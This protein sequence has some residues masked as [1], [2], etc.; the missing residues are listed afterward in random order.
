[1]PDEFD[2]LPTPS[3]IEESDQELGYAM[4]HNPLSRT[5]YSYVKTGEIIIGLGRGGSGSLTIF[6][7]K[8]GDERIT[9]RKILSEAMMTAKWTRQ[10]EGPMLPPFVKAR[11]Q[12]EY[13][14]ALPRS[15]R[16]YFPTASDVIEREIPIPVDLR[17]DG[18][19]THREVIYEMEYVPGEDVS[20]FIEKHSPPTAVVARLYA[21]ILSV[22][23]RVVHTFDRVPAPG[24]TLD[25]SYFKKIEDRLAVCRRTAPSTFNEHLLGT[26]RILINGVPYLNWSTLLARFRK[27]PE[28]L[29]I[30]E[31]PFHSLVMGD[32]NTENIK[33]TNVAPLI[34]AQRLIDSHASAEDVDRAL[35]S[36]TSESLGIRFL[37][38]R[39]VG[40]RSVGREARDDPMYDNKPWHNS[41]GHYD[42]IHHE[43]FTLRIRFDVRHTPCV[44]IE[45]IDGNP[46]QRSYLVREESVD[47]G[48][49]DT[50]APQGMA[51]YFAPIMTALYGLDD[52]DSL[53]VRDDPYWLIRFAFTMGTHFT[54][55][56]PYH[57]QAETDVPFTDNYQIQRRPVAIY[58]EGIKWL[59]WAL[60]MLEGER[61]EFLGL[62]VPS[63]SA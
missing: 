53:H 57:L 58:C 15:V 18:R 5:V 50:A 6:I 59:N 13:L 3:S 37:D 9:V 46:Y 40:F 23:N 32:A 51:D 52:P 38:P 31:P 14:N 45:Y 41:I 34:L 26:G 2:I 61:K 22:L 16:C 11:C 60:Q 43:Y 29:R 62:R 19:T 17:E 27:D 12:A 24:E 25:I 21:E 8:E 20:Q 1:M 48:N 47:C 39:A 49:I 4:G 30:L 33:I 36:I 7:K 35:A 54:A 10:G 44:D 63:P 42:E 28:F 55:M 56:P